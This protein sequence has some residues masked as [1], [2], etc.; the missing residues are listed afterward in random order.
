VRGPFLPEQPSHRKECEPT[1]TGPSNHQSGGGLERILKWILAMLLAVNLLIVL[2]ERVHTIR[3]DRINDSLP[4]ISLDSFR[5]TKLPFLRD[6]VEASAGSISM[7]I[8]VETA[9]PVEAAVSPSRD[10]PS[11]SADEATPALLPTRS[12]SPSATTPAVSSTAVWTS[13]PTASAATSTTATPTFTPTV[14]TPTPV[15]DGNYYVSTSGNDNNPGTSSQPWRTIQKAASSM[16]PGS[17]VIVLIGDYPERVQVTRSGTS[18]SPIAFKAQGTVTMHGFTVHADYIS[19]IGF[20][21]SDTPDNWEDGVGIFLQGSNCDIEDN[22]VHFATRG[23]ITLYAPPGSYSRTSHCVVRDN[24]LYKNAMAGLEIAGQDHL[25]EG[26]EVWGTIQYHPNWAN[27]PNWVDAD[28]I[29]FFG[30]GH[31]IRGNYIHDISL[32]E[33]ENVDP[34]IDCFQT[35]ENS[36]YEYAHNVILEQNRCENLN[37]GM[38]AIMLADADHISIWNN[39]FHSFGGIN[40]GSG[41]NHDLVIANNVFAGDLSFPLNRDPSG[42][43]LENAPN[44]VVKNN[45]FYDQTGPAIYLAGNSEKGLDAGYNSVFRSDG[46]PPSGSPY[47]HDLWGVDPRFVSPGSGNFHL[48]PGSPLVDAGDQ[49]PYV[50][51]DFD[52]NRRPQGSGYDIGAYEGP[53]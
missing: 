30:S 19:L 23:G 42:V 6:F 51:N 3:L 27:P 1:V 33:P 12:D 8:Y 5:I 35:W 2:P 20:D 44:S 41:G 49:L 24:R 7:Q 18:G 47:D 13:T 25:I 16:G 4:A 26:N 37:V 48:L 39:I 45:V 52:G 22:Y 31:T 40:T 28:G 34:H 53:Q 10:A 14:A 29:R 38:Y 21:I 17:T 9:V 11:A 15:P 32:Q 46:V 43:E 50:N 36:N